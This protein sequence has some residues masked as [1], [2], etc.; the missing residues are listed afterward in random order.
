MFTLLYHTIIHRVLLYQKELPW[1]QILNSNFNVCHSNNIAGSFNES[2]TEQIMKTENSQKT[3]NKKKHSNSPHNTI[4]FQYIYRIS[5]TTMDSL[6]E[7]WNHEDK[8]YHRIR[9]NSNSLH[10]FHV[11]S[12]IAISCTQP[13]NGLAQSR[14]LAKEISENNQHLC[15]KENQRNLHP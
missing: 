15:E 12:N 7:P 14:K 6:T 13:M 1:N 9:F 2:K 10:F 5:E 3:K 4:Y 8:K 11:N